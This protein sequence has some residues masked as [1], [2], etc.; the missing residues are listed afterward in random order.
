MDIPWRV[1]FFHSSPHI[2]LFLWLSSTKES[3]TTDFNY[4]MS[5]SHKIFKWNIDTNRDGMREKWKQEVIILRFV[6]EIIKYEFRWKSHESQA[7]IKFEAC[8]SNYSLLTN[9]RFKNSSL[10]PK[11]LKNSYTPIDDGSNHQ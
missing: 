11:N 5:D 4:K 6:L 9:L 2:C 7:M 10:N 3:L 8:Y 1:I